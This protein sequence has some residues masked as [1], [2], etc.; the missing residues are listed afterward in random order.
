MTSASIAFGTSG[1]RGI[2]GD[3]FTFPNL[4]RVTRAV[5]AHLREETATR[6]PRVF[7]GYDT[8][9]LSEQLARE[10]GAVLVAEGVRPRVSSDF[11]P[12]PVVAFAI[13]RWRLDG[14]INLTASH[15]PA[16]YHGFKFSTRD[17]APAPPEVTRRIEARLQDGCDASPAPPVRDAELRPLDPSVEYGRAVLALVDRTPLRR[18]RLRIVADPVFGAGRG[19]LSRLLHGAATVVPIRSNRDVNFGGGGPDCNENNLADCSREVRR[20]RAHL[21]L[22]TDG[23]AD[24][25]GIV[26][27]GGKYVPA[28]LILALLADYLLETRKF[29]SGIAR[30][31]ATTHLLDDVAAHHGVELFETPVGFKHFRDLLVEGRAFLAGEESS[32]LSVAGHVPEKDGILAGL[33]VAEMVARRGKNLHRQIRDLFRRIGPRVS[34]REDHRVTPAQVDLLRRLLESPPGRLAG[35]KVTEVRRVDGTM[36]LRD[37]GSWLLLRPSGTEPLVRCYAEA[38]DARE[39]DRLLAAGRDWVRGR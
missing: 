5:A 15:N 11:V 31:V 4:R 2:L 23:D 25:F 10:V 37:D 19:Y 39:L 35:R 14:G 6:S 26:D 16:E 20:R 38:R 7:V 21:G 13:R 36:L 18:A 17:G 27:T 29:T 8:R 1:W 3:T 9:F 24:R 33:L 32:G 30:T 28:N 22:A 34:R 12:T